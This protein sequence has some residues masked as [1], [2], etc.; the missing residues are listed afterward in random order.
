MQPSRWSSLTLDPTYAPMIP[1]ARHDDAGGRRHALRRLHAQGRAGA[2]VRFRA[3]CRRAPTC[4]R[5]GL[6][7]CTGRPAST[8]STWSRRWT[9]SAS[10]L[11]RSPMTARHRRR[12][13]IRPCSGA[14]ASPAL[15]PPTSCCCR[16]RCGPGAGGDMSPSIQAIFHW[17][18]A[19]IALPV[20]GYAGQPFFAS[21]AQALRAGRLNMDVPISLGVVAGDAHEPVPDHARQRAGLLRCRGHAAVLP[22]G[23]ALP[24]PAHA[25]ARGRCR[26]QSAR[27]AGIGRDRPAAGWRHGAAPGPSAGARHAHPDG[28]RRALRCRRPAAAA[29][30]ARST[31]V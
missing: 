2:D 16:C 17:L 29:A 23:R 13:P 26:R 19:L 22:A 18:S 11:P 6:P 21:A 1:P 3:S 28:A 9:G 30:P 27:L 4:R 5:G 24:G 31:P 7:R 8:A 10:R 20:V 25:H 15:Q 14:S 12:R